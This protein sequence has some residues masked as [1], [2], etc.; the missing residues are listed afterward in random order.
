MNNRIKY[1]KVDINKFSRK[2]NHLNKLSTQSRPFSNLKSTNEQRKKNWN[3]LLIY[4]KNPDYDIRKDKNF[5]ITNMRNNDV[6][7]IN[8]ITYQQSK[9]F[10]NKKNNSV[11]GLK[12]TMSGFF[13]HYNGRPNDYNTSR[14]IISP[15]TNSMLTKNT[16]M[17]NT[18][19]SMNMNIISNDENLDIIK[20]LWN[21]LSVFVSYRELFTII[22][23]QL[24]GEEKEQ[25]LKKEI[26]DLNTVKNNIK[27]LNYYIGQRNIVL[28]DLYEQNKKLNKSKYNNTNS[29]QEIL[30]EISNIIEKLRES[31][32][33]VCYAMKKFKN[34]INNVSNLSKYNLD[35]ICNKNKF[36][37]NYLIKMKGELNFLK[38]GKA[39]IYFNLNNECSPFLLKTSDTNL[40]MNMFNNMN[41]NNSNEN[42]F[43][44]K[45]V[46][47]K[48][49]IK[50]HI[51]KCNFYIY[52]ELIAYQQSI[53]SQNKTFR[54]VSPLKSSIE[55]I[56]YNY[57]TNYVNKE[58]DIITNNII[59]ESELYRKVNKNIFNEYS[60]INGFYSKNNFIVDNKLKNIQNFIKQKINERSNKD[61]FSQKLFSPY[62]T[63]NVGNNN[64]IEGEKVKEKEEESKEE[65]KKREKEEGEEKEDDE[66]REDE[67][68]DENGE[69]KEKK[70]D[71]EENEEEDEEEKE[72]EEDG[73]NEEN[74]EEEENE[75]NEEDEENEGNEKD[76]TNSKNELND[77]NEEKK[78]KIN[79]KKNSENNENNNKSEKI[80]NIER[81]NNINKEKEN[82]INNIRNISKKENKE[83]N[84]KNNIIRNNKENN[85]ISK[86]KVNNFNNNTIKEENKNNITN[87]K[88]NNNDLKSNK[89]NKEKENLISDKENIKEERDQ[90]SIEIIINSD[91]E[92]N[93][94]DNENK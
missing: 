33:D 4:Y 85:N 80:K 69:E 1:Q 87:K 73:K 93:K 65:N 40:N 64:L 18:N 52:Q 51:N 11:R 29:N 50:E 72:K 59:N 79:N 49:E 37:K 42:E 34:D 83:R 91:N 47:L 89:K 60:N 70:E 68:E 23:N 43:F 15:L 56:N 61:L 17:N 92:V 19:I 63:P 25:L 74:E 39:K 12:R 94:N 36:D 27:I 21:E 9:K 77:S 71:G 16:L 53:L 44:M 88:K 8:Y 48:E 30:V 76:E 46:P 90:N 45:T 3:K 28:K 84:D 38:K 78:D 31:T 5:R 66:E 57:N 14:N 10:E 20:N 58:N 22:Y 2:L 32:V 7:N 26:N 24:S 35:V 54:S 55:N 82:D 75:G 86:K 6:F 13:T 81:D 62:M 67:E 41:I